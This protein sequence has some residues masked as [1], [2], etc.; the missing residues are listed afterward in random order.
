MNIKFLSLCLFFG[1]VSQSFSQDFEGFIRYG[2]SYEVTNTSSDPQRIIKKNRLE[3]NDSVLIAYAK[4]GDFLKYIQNIKNAIYS[5]NKGM[6]LVYTFYKG[7]K[8]VTVTNALYGM[9]RAARFESKAVELDSIVNVNGVDCKRVQFEYR[10]HTSTVYY[11]VD[12]KYKGLGKVF[13]YMSFINQEIRFSS[14]R[15]FLVVRFEK[16]LKDAKVIVDL[17]DFKKTTIDSSVFYIPD[18]KK[19]SK[20]DYDDGPYNVYKIKDKKYKFLELPL[21]L[22]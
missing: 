11:S 6:D 8:T 13:Y 3:K 20:Y 14:I 7:D 12:E 1:F 18:Y 19:S 21:K 17:L 5:Y 16:E 15:D 9:D 10:D 4:N 2:A 22:N